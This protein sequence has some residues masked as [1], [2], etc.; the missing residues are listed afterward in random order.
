ML[1]I[2]SNKSIIH[3]IEKLTVQNIVGVKNKKSIIT[4][5]AIIFF[6]AFKNMLEGIAFCAF[7]VIVIFINN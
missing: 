5:N 2:T 3:F 7:F 1:F 4:L 6:Y